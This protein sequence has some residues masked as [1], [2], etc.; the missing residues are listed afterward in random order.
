MSLLASVH[1]HHGRS[2]AKAG[3]RLP[4]LYDEIFATRD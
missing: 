2:E 1:C 4:E 3:R